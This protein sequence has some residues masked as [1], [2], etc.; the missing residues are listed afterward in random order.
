[1]SGMDDRLEVLI[2]K[3]LDGQ[4]TPVEQ[5]WLEREVNRNLEAK[6][7]FERWRTVHEWSRQAVAEEIVGKGMAPE[8]V[9]ER[10]WQRHKGFSWRRVVRA[11]GHLRFAVGLA[12]GFLLGVILHFSLVWMNGTTD[13]VETRRGLVAQNSTTQGSENVKMVSR[14]VAAPSRSVT[15]NVDWYGFTDEAGNRWLVEGVQEGMVRPAVYR[16]SL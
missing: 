6:E 1:M 11:D 9:F 3:C 2:G 14:S 7:L 5:H 10:A 13:A 15:R 8:E 4:A 16:G 12:A